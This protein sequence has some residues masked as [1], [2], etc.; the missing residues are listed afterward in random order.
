MRKS[1]SCVTVSTSGE[2]FMIVLTRAR[3]KLEAAEAGEDILIELKRLSKSS[4]ETNK[5]K[6]IEKCFCSQSQIL[7]RLRLAVFVVYIYG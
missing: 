4:S 7:N 3:G 2:L 5:P 1:V 6:L